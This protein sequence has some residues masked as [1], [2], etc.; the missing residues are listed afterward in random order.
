MSYASVLYYPSYN[1]STNILGIKKPVCN[2]RKELLRIIKID[3]IHA[4]SWGIYFQGNTGHKA[5][6]VN[7]TADALSRQR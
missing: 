6:Q 1:A 7:T 5:E 2:L 3:K 4:V